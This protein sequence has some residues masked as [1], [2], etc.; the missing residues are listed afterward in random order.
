M[1]LD[2]NNGLKGGQESHLLGIIHNACQFLCIL[3]DSGSIN[4]M[5]GKHFSPIKGGCINL[6]KAHLEKDGFSQ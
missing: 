5:E 4:V 1:F 2:V 3:L 6:H